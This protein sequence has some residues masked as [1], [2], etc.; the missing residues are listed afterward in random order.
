[1]LTVVISRTEPYLN[2]AL[3]IKEACASVQ[4]NCDIY[5]IEDILLNKNET[6]SKNKSECLIYFLTNTDTI[7]EC[8]KSFESSNKNILINRDFF[9]SEKNKFSV[10]NRLRLAEV[11]VP[12]SI[13]VTNK[14]F[15]GAVLQSLK[16]PLYIKSQ[17]QAN[18]VIRVETDKEFYDNM[19]GRSIK[20][21]YFEESVDLEKFH[22]EKI[23]YVGG[24]IESENKNLVITDS[25]ETEL[26]NISNLLEL[27]IYSADVFASI[28]SNTYYYIDINPA[29]ALFHSTKA[30]MHFA[31]YMLDKL[32]PHLEK[33]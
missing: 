31:K 8:I 22:L 29:P 24:H 7:P 32:T 11:Y 26:K 18:T 9:I 6:L 25:L 12:D 19:L 17:K 13:V 15:F 3:F 16:L 30:R 33:P 1:M 21:F 5:Y 4:L 10:Q 20:D 23:Y 27:E 2:G 14:S 28:S